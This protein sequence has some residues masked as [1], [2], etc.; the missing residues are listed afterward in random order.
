ML[1]FIFFEAGLAINTSVT[2][3]SHHSW[4]HKLLSLK[5]RWNNFHA[6]YASA[7]VKK[8]KNQKDICEG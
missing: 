1:Y 5:W 4:K 6:P 2:Q 3:K 7:P 8:I